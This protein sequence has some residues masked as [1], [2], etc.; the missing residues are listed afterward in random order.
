M[1][2]ILNILIIGKLIYFLFLLLLYSY[3]YKDFIKNIAPFTP[4]VK[5]T[6]VYQQKNEGQ[7]I[8]KR[9]I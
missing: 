7:H 5:K 3:I 9:G 1:G 2:Y 4:K 8:K 6:L